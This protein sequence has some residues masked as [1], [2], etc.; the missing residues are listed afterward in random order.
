MKHE[1][2]KL[3]LKDG[4]YVGEN[5]TICGLKQLGIQKICVLLN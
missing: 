3:V 2:I 5:L 4:K 1:D